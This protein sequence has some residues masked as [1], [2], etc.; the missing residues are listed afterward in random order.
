[1]QQL[2]KKT[3]REAVKAAFGIP[4]TT[5]NEIKGDALS[6][7]YAKCQNKENFND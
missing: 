2:K 7:L 4:E 5:V 3:M 6:A 1:M